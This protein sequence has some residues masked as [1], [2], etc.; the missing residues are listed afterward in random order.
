M[1]QENAVKVTL[2]ELAQQEAIKRSGGPR[3]VSDVEKAR[4]EAM[5]LEQREREKIINENRYSLRTAI[6]NFFGEV[7]NRV[8]SPMLLMCVPDMIAHHTVLGSNAATRLVISEEPENTEQVGEFINTLIGT[9]QYVP[10]RAFLAQKLARNY[11][12]QSRTL[13]ECYW[14]YE[15][16]SFLGVGNSFFGNM[17]SQILFAKDVNLGALDFTKILAPAS[18]TATSSTKEQ[19]LFG[20]A[21]QQYADLEALLSRM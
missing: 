18:T 16:C 2:T 7:A 10:A 6:H 8:Q 19:M 13:A 21:A 17:I 12:A 1:S 11:N 5:T 20:L 14:L 9:M 15:L 3:P 4:L